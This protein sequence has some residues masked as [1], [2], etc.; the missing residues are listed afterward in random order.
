MY[1]KSFFRSR[2]QSFQHARN[3]LRNLF[4]TQ[5][6]GKIEGIIVLIVV[7]FGI[8]LNLN[9]T[10][11]LF[12]IFAIGIVFLAEIFNT[13]IEFL[14]DSLYSEYNYKVKQIKDMSAGGVLVAAIISAIIGCLIFLPKLI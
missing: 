7:T 5:I 13:V 9:R 12:V 6:N 2:A 8:F 14:L 10:E 4:S 1:I 3:G 11:W